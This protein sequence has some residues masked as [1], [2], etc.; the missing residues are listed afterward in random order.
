MRDGRGRTRAQCE[1]WRD[2]RRTSNHEVSTEKTR[3]FET[4]RIGSVPNDMASV[5]KHLSLGSSVLNDMESV[6]KN[7]GG[8]R[9]QTSGPGIECAERYAERYG[10][11]VRLCDTARREQICVDA[12]Q[13]NRRYATLPLCPE[14]TIPTPQ[15]WEGSTHPRFHRSISYMVTR[16]H[17]YVWH[18]C[19]CS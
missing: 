3:Y 4:I 11:D 16:C 6:N 8:I 7:L 19:G 17:R 15:P 10:I 14:C 5:N 12:I 13:I 1:R 2:K 18:A 9:K